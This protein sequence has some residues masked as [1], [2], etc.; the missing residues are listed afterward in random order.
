MFLH[1]LNGPQKRQTWR[2]AHFGKKWVIFPISKLQFSEEP[3]LEAN[4]KRCHNTFPVE[5]KRTPG[6]STIPEDLT[7]PPNR[8]LIVNSLLRTCPIRTSFFSGS[9]NPH[10]GKKVWSEPDSDLAY[11][12]GSKNPHGG[13]ESMVR[14][15]LH[16]SL[17]GWIEKSTRW[18]RSMVRT[19]LR[20]SLFGW[21]EKST[22]WKRSMVRTRLRLS[23]FGWI[24]KSTRWKRKYGPNQTS[25]QPIWVDRKIHT[26]E[27]KKYGP[28]QTSTQPILVDRKIHTVER[29]RRFKE[30]F[31]LITKRKF[32][33]LPP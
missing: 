1:L 32:S 18:K 3:T 20:L 27:K 30:H 29:D 11:L 2:N 23:L 7:F 26:V 31:G 6:L 12:G 24:K 28:N 22:R 10:C 16:L 33:C 8:S 19:R 14:T 15:R 4:R 13:K 5:R 25:P 17:F 9:K 21:N